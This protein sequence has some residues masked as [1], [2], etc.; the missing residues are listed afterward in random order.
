[1]HE[2]RSALNAC[3]GRA[4]VSGRAVPAPVCVRRGGRGERTE[5]GLHGSDGWA[6]ISGFDLI[7]IV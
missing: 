7:L 3:R 2:L 4:G 5:C 6:Q 1:M